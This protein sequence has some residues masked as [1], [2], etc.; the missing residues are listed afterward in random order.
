MIWMDRVYKDVFT[1]K[2]SEGI[3]IHGGICD[4]AALI[5]MDGILALL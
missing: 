1:A 4:G 2:I 3:S 5:W